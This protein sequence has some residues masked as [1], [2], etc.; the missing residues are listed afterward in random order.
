MD[1]VMHASC[2]CHERPIAS[3]VGPEIWLCMLDVIAME[4]L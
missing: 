2:Y 1:L 4:D 3:E